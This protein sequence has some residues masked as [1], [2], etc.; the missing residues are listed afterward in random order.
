MVTRTISAMPF[1]GGQFNQ[2]GL[3]Q[4]MVRLTPSRMVWVYSQ[5]NPNWIISTIIDTQGGY[6]SANMPVATTQ[7]LTIQGTLNASSYVTN[8]VRLTDSTFM[9]ISS[10][11]FTNANN[12]LPTYYWI[13]S[14]DNTNTISVVD[15]GSYN[16]QIAYSFQNTPA[17]SVNNTVYVELADNLISVHHQP[18]GSTPTYWY[19]YNLVVNPATN[20]LVPPVSGDLR[21][22]ASNLPAVGSNYADWHVSKIPD[23][24][25]YTMIT[26]RYGINSSAFAMN[27]STSIIMDNTGAV[28]MAPNTLPQNTPSSTTTASGYADMV[29]MQG[30][31]L[32]ISSVK[33]ATV[34][35]IDYSAK[36][37]R[38]ISTSQFS[39]NSNPDTY[40]RYVIPLNADYW[41]MATRQHFWLPGTT[42]LMRCKVVRR[43][44]AQLIEQ[45][46]ASV[47]NTG[48]GFAITTAPTTFMNGVSQYPELVNGKIFYWG[49]DAASTGNVAKL[50]WS[51]LSLP[52]S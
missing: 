19:Y 20:K 32:V 16:P 45:S 14:I 50:S 27:G 8:A 5:S 42:P 4:A 6:T 29:P 43:V 11:W 30:D 35:A 39:S 49:F 51:V 47:G 7:Q 46:A 23:R 41:F 34:Y 9:I 13:C 12:T 36:T 18:N 44:D 26:R 15:S 21:T 2:N 38:Q 17:Q 10:V 22:V 37:W 28:Y 31:R 3:Q 1:L 33:D 48:N 24:P 40:G 52:A 25:Q